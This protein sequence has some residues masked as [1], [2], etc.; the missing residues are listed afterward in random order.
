[1][2]WIATNQTSQIGW[3]RGSEYER[4]GEW[5]E[6]WIRDNNYE[7]MMESTCTCPPSSLILVSF[8][9]WKFSD[10]KNRVFKIG[11]YFFIKENVYGQLK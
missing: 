1:M 3:C 6:S 5:H 10:R 9:W 8:V 2:N 4:R 7:S 11:N